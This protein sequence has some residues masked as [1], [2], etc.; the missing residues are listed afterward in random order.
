[1]IF[2]DEWDGLV[3]DEGNR[4]VGKMGLDTKT[5]SDAGG[6][7]EEIKSLEGRGMRPAQLFSLSVWVG[8]VVGE[9]E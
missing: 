1:M 4:F 3:V 8:A 2:L 9:R 7:T 5:F 6:E